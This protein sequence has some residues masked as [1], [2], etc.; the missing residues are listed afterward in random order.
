VKSDPG[1]VGD[2]MTR[3]YGSCDVFPDTPGEAYRPFQSLNYVTSHDGL[4][5]YDLVSYNSPESWNC[6]ARDGESDI[7]DEVIALRKRQARNFVCLLM[8]SNGTPM[9]RAGDEFLQTQDG[10]INPY[11]NDGP[12]TWLDWGR[13]QQHIDI[14]R[15]FQKMTDFRKGHPSLAR[16]LFW[17]DDVKWYGPN[18]NLDWSYDSRTLAWC[19]HGASLDDSDIYVMVNAYW[20]PLTFTI[21]EG[22]TEQWKRVIDTSLFSPDDFIDLEHAITLASLN[23]RLA[24]RSIVALVRSSTP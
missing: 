13:L 10:E 5:L 24:P 18:H 4:T 21:Q 3:I 14:V 9:F 6:G 22:H 1:F 11:N 7:S 19:V 23:Y 2:L 20:E 8:L 12:Q 15:F 16:S 17:R